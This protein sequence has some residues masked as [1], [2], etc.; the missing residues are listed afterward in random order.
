MNNFV[1]DKTANN[2]EIACKLC[3]KDYTY[4]EVIAELE[5]TN[6]IKKQACILSLSELRTQEDANKLIDN[7]TGQDGR[8]RE[9]VAFKIN[10]LIKNSYY[11][12]FFQS[13]EASDTFING[14]IDVNP[15]ICRFIIE[16]LDYVDDKKYLV[17]TL[18]QQVQKI[19]NDVKNAGKDIEKHVLKKKIFK[20]YWTL[21]A[22]T[23]ILKNHPTGEDTTELETIIQAT[24]E[25]S[26]YTIR[27]KVYR[28]LKVI[29]AQC[30][31]AVFEN[32]LQKLQNDENFYVT[33]N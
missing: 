4:G 31:N 7:L 19:D 12:A 29:N 17:E 2:A 24:I 23:E 10:E 27:E 8:I 6:V 20:L 3:E 16:A 1:E 18:I 32:Y 15:A 5:C 33:L 21:E 9:V 26:E 14:I 13:R 28:L 25:H 30:K 22:L 11:T